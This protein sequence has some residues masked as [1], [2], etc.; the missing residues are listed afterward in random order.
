L[1]SPFSGDLGVKRRRFPT[2]TFSY[3]ESFP[4]KTFSY[5]VSD[6]LPTRSHGRNTVKLHRAK[7]RKP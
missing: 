4:T 7:T 1:K 5:H 3:Q 2:K 6:K